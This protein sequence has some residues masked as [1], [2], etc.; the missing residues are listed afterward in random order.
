MAGRA[1]TIDSDE[2]SKLLKANGWSWPDP[3]V[4]ASIDSTNRALI[5][6]DAAEGVVLIAGEQ[7]SGRG[8]GS[9][10]WLAPAGTSILMSIA[11]RPTAPVM[12]WPWVGVLAALAV[13]GAVNG[14]FGDSIDVALKWPNDIVATSDLSSLA[15]ASGHDPHRYKLGGVLSEVSGGLCVIGVGVNVLQN[16]SQLPPGATS[17]A[18]LSQESYSLVEFASDILVDFKNRFLTWNTDWALPHDEYVRDEYASVCE[19]VDKNVTCL[20]AEQPVS[21]HAIG[22]NQW[23]QLIVLT[24]QSGELALDSALVSNLRRVN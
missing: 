6:A 13:R 14:R 12:S 5:A 3:S 11:L 20:Y 23:G 24:S 17:L 15:S 8:R 18:Q 4:V 21:G 1:G 22:V 16:V 9:N 10:L 7:T 2:L 19:T